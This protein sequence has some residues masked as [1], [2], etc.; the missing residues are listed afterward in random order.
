MIIALFGEH[1]RSA[2]APLSGCTSF[3][4]HV[5]AELRAAESTV[6]NSTSRMWF[7]EPQQFVA[8]AVAHI[9][10][11]DVEVCFENDPRLDKFLVETV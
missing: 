7:M 1:Q 4:C 8:S 3:V 10:V 5:G 2:T 11:Q 6:S 9:E